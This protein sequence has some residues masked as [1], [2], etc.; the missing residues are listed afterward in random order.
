MTRQAQQKI[1]ADLD[2]HWSK[3]CLLLYMQTNWVC[4]SGTQRSG[5][6]RVILWKMWLESSHHFSQRDSSR[7]RV[8][9]N[10]DSSRV[11][12]SSHTITDSR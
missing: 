12:D 3:K 2:H 7:A 11:I 8:T 9:K 5:T 4:P 1:S 10:R 6:S